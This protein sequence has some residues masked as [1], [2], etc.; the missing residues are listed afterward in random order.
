MPV[1]LYEAALYLALAEKMVQGRNVAIAI[2]TPQNEVLG[3][4]ID[5]A[6]GLFDS[7]SAIINLLQHLA[8]TKT[9][10]MNKYFIVTT[11]EPSLKCLGMAKMQGIP[12]ILFD[13]EERIGAYQKGKRYSQRENLSDG[14]HIHQLITAGPPIILDSLPSIPNFATLNY[15]ERML[16]VTKWWHDRR[17]EVAPNLLQSYR[18]AP[19]WKRLM[20]L[21]FSLPPGADARG[22][23][24]DDSKLRHRIFLSL[25]WAIVGHRI[26]G[27]FGYKYKNAGPEGP[28]EK[29][30]HNIGCVLRGPNDEILGWGLN[31]FSHNSTWHG[32]VNLIQNYHRRNPGRQ[33]PDKSWLYTTLKPCHMCASMFAGSGNKLTCYYGQ[34]DNNIQSSPPGVDMQHLSFEKV[35]NTEDNLTKKPGNGDKTTK[36]L[37]KKDVTSELLN[38]VDRYRALEAETI[39]GSHDRKIWEAGLKILN[40]AYST[41][42]L[43]KHKMEHQRTYAGVL[44]ELLAR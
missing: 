42:I 7:R 43:A 33:I 24:H 35:N 20:N 11:G 9:F 8:A 17:N 12:N 14:S 36:S 28:E 23:Q 27:P 30:G 38:A 31:T 40:E 13:S 10:N 16:R 44:A 39:E 19:R 4:G 34:D 3:I 41:R 29:E 37:Y 26:D 22:G 32:E 25:A 6:L 15:A 21:E 18:F 2:S 1:S 5:D